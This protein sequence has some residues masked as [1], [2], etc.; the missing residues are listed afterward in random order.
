MAEGGGKSSG[1]GAWGLLFGVIVVL[2]VIV[3]MVNSDTVSQPGPAP[4]LNLEYYFDRIYDIGRAVVGFFTGSSEYG[5]GALRTFISVVAIIFL[6]LVLYFF[7]RIY[8]LKH[9]ERRRIKDIAYGNV[10]RQQAEP[11]NRRWQEVLRHANSENPNDW[12]LAIMEA[13]AM[14]DEYTDDLGYHGETLGERL[15]N[16]EKGDIRTLQQAWDAHIIRNKIAHEGFDYELTRREARR[17]VGLYE[18][19][20]K[21]LGYL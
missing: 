2:F 12:R 16:M 14:L 9:R 19:V 8:E 18:T 7:V 11:H 6:V 4:F 21:E 13:D 17:V 20:F 5:G 10:E 1:L 3:F 15:K